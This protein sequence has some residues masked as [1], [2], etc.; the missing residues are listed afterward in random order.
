MEKM[1]YEHG[2]GSSKI[3]VVKK[4]KLNVLFFYFLCDFATCRGSIYEAYCIF[5]HK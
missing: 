2:F 4:E 1:I 3:G 5:V